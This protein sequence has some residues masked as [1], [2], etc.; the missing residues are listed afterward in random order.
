[1][2]DELWF[3]Y[4]AI[5][6]RGGWD[7]VGT[8]P[9]GEHI[10]LPHLDKDQGAICLAVL[11][12]DGFIS[13]DAADTEGSVQTVPFTLRGSTLV[14]NVDALQGE[15]RVEALQGNGRVV[16]Q[17]E[18]LT[19]NLMSEPVKWAQGNLADLKGQTASLRFTL[20]KAQFY[21]YWLQ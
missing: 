18:P 20:R 11:R 16:A 19:G 3:Y 21:S 1:M 12:R 7:Y 2:R 6:Y 5:K 14:V 8:Y 10:S 9:H 4:T 13:L 15:L 17:S